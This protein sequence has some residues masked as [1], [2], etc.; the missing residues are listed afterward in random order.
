MPWWKIFFFPVKINKK[1]NQNYLQ[2]AFP[3]NDT[4]KIDLFLNIFFSIS[5]YSCKKK[6]KIYSSGKDSK[7]NY[8]TI[9]KNFLH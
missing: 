5:D 7:T 3:D 8:E 9:N 4:V 1:F 6:K 2:N